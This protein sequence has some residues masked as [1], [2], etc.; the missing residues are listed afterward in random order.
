M[1]GSRGSESTEVL[2]GSSQLSVL[3]CQFSV[4]SFRERIRA[5]FLFV[6]TITARLMSKRGQSICGF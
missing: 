4:L 2:K 5:P 6:R 3:S 1:V